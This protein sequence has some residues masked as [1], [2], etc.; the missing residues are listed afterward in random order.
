M[1]NFFDQSSLRLLFEPYQ[2]GGWGD[3]VQRGQQLQRCQ[4]CEDKSTTKTTKKKTHTRPSRAKPVA[5]VATIGL[6]K[7]LPPRWPHL[8]RPGHAFLQHHRMDTLA[9]QGNLW[10]LHSI[11]F[12][13]NYPFQKIIYMYAHILYLHAE[14]CAMHAWGMNAWD[15]LNKT[16]RF[17]PS[18][19]TWYFSSIHQI[20]QSS[21]EDTRAVSSEVQSRLC[22]IIKNGCQSSSH[23]IISSSHHLIISISYLFVLLAAHG[24]VRLSCLAF[25]ARH[26]NV[27]PCTSQHE[28]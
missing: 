8:A 21:P 13:S 12:L 10:G 28:Y 26:E 11:F 18:F 23:L 4:G 19:L 17:K 5:T 20:Q 9:N 7:K 24:T 6:S 3:Q 1:I 14:F 27:L 15:T 22:G 16:Y 2:A 25:L